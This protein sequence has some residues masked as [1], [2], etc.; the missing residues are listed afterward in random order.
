M[1]T[2]NHTSPSGEELEPC[3]FC[4]GKAESQEYEEVDATRW[5]GYVRCGN[6][7]VEGPRGYANNRMGCF[8]AVN[9]LHTKA[10]KSAWNRR[11]AGSGE[12][13]ANWATKLLDAIISDLEGGFVRCEHCGE[14]EDTATLDVVP[15]LRDLRTLLAANG[16]MPASYDAWLRQERSRRADFTPLADSWARSAWKACVALTAANGA[17]GEREATNDLEQ[18]L[19]DGAETASNMVYEANCQ[20]DQELSD[21]GALMWKLVDALK[22][23]D[24]R[25]ALTAEKVAGQE[26]VS[27]THVNLFRPST[28]DV[29]KALRTDSIDELLQDGW[30]ISSQQQPAQSAEQD[31]RAMAYSQGFE[32]GKRYVRAIYQ[33][34]DVS[35][36]AQPVQVE[37]ALPRVHGVSRMA[38]NPC[39][40]LLLLM[41]EPADDDLRAILDRLTT[42]PLASGGDQ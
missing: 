15:M 1:T 21:R 38:D 5:V 37:R 7:S 2:T 10:A 22:R 36:A 19:E 13:A 20:M 11:A 26:A 14:Q 23:S 31:E 9:G 41:R 29:F 17:M 25:A 42:L 6:C 33:T 40:L 34:R 30:E 3:P 12:D 39:A 24:I 16:A 28:G 27:D 35:T 8:D 18:L 4:G 32:D